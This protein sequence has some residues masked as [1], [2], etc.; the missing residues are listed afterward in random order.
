M[1][2]GQWMV[3]CALPSCRRVSLLLAVDL[4]KSSSLQNPSSHKLL[5]LCKRGRQPHF[6]LVLNMVYVNNCLHAANCRD[7]TVRIS[8]D[9]WILVSSN[10]YYQPAEVLALCYCRSRLTPLQKRLSA[11]NQNWGRR[12][13][14]EYLVTVQC[15]I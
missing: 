7:H 6:E 15:P 4:R 2:R 5:L 9:G 10:Y 12:G 1:R 13:R 8:H 14:A 3:T 11:T